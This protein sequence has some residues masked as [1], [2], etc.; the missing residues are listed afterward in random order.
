MDELNARKMS[1]AYGKSKDSIDEWQG[2]Y[3]FMLHR[4]AHR[5]VRQLLPELAVL[6]GSLLNYLREASGRQ[7]LSCL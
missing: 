3:A 2:T 1:H 4:G 5:L 7:L 6:S